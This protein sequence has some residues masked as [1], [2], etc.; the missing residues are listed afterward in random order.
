MGLC[1]LQ[2]VKC[3]AEICKQ[4]AESQIEIDELMIPFSWYFLINAQL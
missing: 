4:I 2:I 1:E 3:F